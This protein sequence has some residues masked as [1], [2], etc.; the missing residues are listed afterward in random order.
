MTVNLN[1]DSQIGLLLAERLG[2]SLPKREGHDLAGPCIACK[3]SDAIRL[4]IQTGVAQCYSCGGKWSPFQVAEAVTGDREQAKN[5]LVELGLFKPS[6]NGN[7]QAV[8]SDPIDA[9]AKQKGVTADAL[10][11]FGAKVLTDTKIEFP[12]YGPDCEQ[13]TTFSIS[14]KVGTKGNKGIFAKGKKAGL[15]FPH[16]DGV[17]RLPKPGETWHLV[18]GPKDACALHGL[19]LLAC[20]LNTCR[21][22]AKFARLF[23]GVDIVVIPDR[24]RAGEQGAE[25]SA[26]V[27]RGVASS[28]RIAV[29]PVE[30]KESD[31][32]DVRDVLRRPDGRELVAQAIDDARLWEPTVSQEDSADH[33]PEVEITPDEHKVNDAAIAAISTDKQLFQ[34]GGAL[35]QIQR[36]HGHETLKGITRPANAPRIV[37]IPDATLRERLT[38]LVRFVKRSGSDEDEPFEHVHPP[39]SA[40]RPWRHEVIGKACAT[41]RESSAARFCAR[42]AQCFRRPDTIRP[43]AFY[44]SPMAERSKCLTS[45]ILTTR[46]RRAMY[47]W[48]LF[49]IF[50]SPRQLINRPGSHWC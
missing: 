35:V 46:S 27:L 50:P 41:W 30:F 40:S 19:E 42:M 7:G 11:A 45:P 1:R 33:R 15:F 12:G 44:S 18:E 34:R 38:A 22:A 4:H 3:S 8:P 10:K 9:I 6:L 47:C 28:V 5:L 25:H 14:T 13:C 43:P 32:E 31:G 37:I 2:L 23:A 39:P 17:V 26:R 21:M 48:R 49:T 24:D 29:L 20:G 16:V 36:D